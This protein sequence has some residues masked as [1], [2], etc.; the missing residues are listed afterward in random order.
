MN[1]PY[2]VNFFAEE[3][4]Y[5]TYPELEAKHPLLTN[6]IYIALIGLYGTALALLSYAVTLFYGKNR[7]SVIMIP[8]IFALILEM[9]SSYTS[10][11]FSVSN[12]LGVMTSVHIGSVWPITA[13]FLLISVGSISAIFFYAKTGQEE[14]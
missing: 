2:D 10:Y 14:A 11:W 1:T 5:I 13:M 9:S 7:A 12:A 4:N 3:E 6:A 8:L